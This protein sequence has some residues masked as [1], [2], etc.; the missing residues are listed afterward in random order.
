M[1]AQ[2]TIH[3]YHVVFAYAAVFLAI[4]AVIAG[5]L[6]RREAMPLLDKEPNSAEGTPEAE[7][8]VI[9]A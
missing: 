6:L 8:V 9:A 3:G 7:H 4:E 2:A 1:Q 5:L